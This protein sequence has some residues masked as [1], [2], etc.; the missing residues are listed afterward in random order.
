MTKSPSKEY[1]LEYQNIPLLRKTGNNSDVNDANG[2]WVRKD[3]QK[4][5][6]A[7]K[8]HVGGLR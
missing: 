5:P 2:C 3:I 4:S 6:H 7:T 1:W 8:L